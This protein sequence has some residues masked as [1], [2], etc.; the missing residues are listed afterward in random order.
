[1]VCHWEKID[2]FRS[3]IE[4]KRFS[5]WLKEQV[6]KGNALELPIKSSYGGEMLDEK[7]IQCSD[8]G[9]VWRLVSP[10]P[11]YF[12]GYWDLV[13]ESDQKD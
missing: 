11:G 3:I 2:G 13:P 12:D 9:A 10:D 5:I 8:C 6:Q 4:F 7:W 1:M